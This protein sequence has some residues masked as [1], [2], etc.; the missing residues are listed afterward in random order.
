MTEGEENLI[1]EHRLTNGDDYRYD[2]IRLPGKPP[3]SC[4]PT[5]HGGGW[6]V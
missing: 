1:Y 4:L 2:F 3:L 5:R 6:G